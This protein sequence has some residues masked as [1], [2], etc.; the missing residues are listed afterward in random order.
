LTLS[1]QVH[2]FEII[3]GSGESWV[4]GDEKCASHGGYLAH[5]NSANL[6]SQLKTYISA[7][8]QKPLMI[9]ATVGNVNTGL[10]ALMCPS[11]QFSSIVNTSVL[12]SLFVGNAST[13]DRCVFLEKSDFKLHYLACDTDADILCDFRRANPFF[14]V[15]SV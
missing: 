13:V 1:G 9:G 7:N 2:C 10:V 4:S 8:Y 12:S 14:H 6:I 3:H 11:N 5:L 15:Y